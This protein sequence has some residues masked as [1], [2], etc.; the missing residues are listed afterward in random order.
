MQSFQCLF[1]LNFIITL[2]YS[3]T[4]SD[5]NNGNLFE[6]KSLFIN[7]RIAFFCWE[8]MERYPIPYYVENGLSFHNIPYYVWESHSRI[9]LK[10]ANGMR[11]LWMEY[12]FDIS[13]VP[14]LFN[15]FYDNLLNLVKNSH[16]L[17]W[18]WGYILGLLLV[19][20]SM[21]AMFYTVLWNDIVYNLF[22]FTD[23]Y[24][25]HLLWQMSY[26]TCKTMEK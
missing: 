22:Y 14:L 7:S 6:K 11:Y 24:I 10:I 8:V 5:N 13:N 4:V 2:L 23:Y 20:R 15:S 26:I 19:V 3:Y 18:K 1:S 9:N 25:W 21:I 16:C 17:I 12:I